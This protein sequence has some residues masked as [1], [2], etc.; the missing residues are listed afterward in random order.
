MSITIAQER[1]DVP[2]A[3]ALVEELESILS[4]LYPDESR[5][6]YSVQKLIEQNVHFFVVRCDNQPAACGGVQ[7]F[8]EN[9]PPYG[10]LKRMYVRPAFRG[11][12]LAKR[13]LQ[14]FEEVAATQQIATLRLETGIHQTEAIQ[15]Y[16]RSGY[17]RIG[18]FGEYGDDPNS[19]FYEKQL[20][21][22]STT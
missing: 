9:H 15:L 21:F 1:P 14:H 5:H 10:E 13:L 19:L 11:R 12:G 8:T 16:E 7:F 20:P 2:D 6:G 22:I 4:P 17:Q 18:P 3:I